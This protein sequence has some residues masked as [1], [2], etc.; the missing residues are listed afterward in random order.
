MSKDEVKAL[1]KRLGD[2]QA[3]FARRVGVHTMTVSR[4]ER[5]RVSIPV[6]MALLIRERTKQRARPET[7]RRS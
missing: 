3:Q 5:G 2:T 6:A 4:W 1:R 7:K